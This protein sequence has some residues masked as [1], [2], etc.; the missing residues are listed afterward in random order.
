MKIIK[1]IFALINLN[2]IFLLRLKSPD[3]PLSQAGL[4]NSGE[5]KRKH[6]PPEHLFIPLLNTIVGDY[7]PYF[8]TNIS[9]YA[10]DMEKEIDKK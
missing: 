10:N 3:I 9:K 6:E 8:N 4:T 7:N 1:L 2:I 5:F